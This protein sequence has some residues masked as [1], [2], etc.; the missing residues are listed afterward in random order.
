MIYR[1]AIFGSG[2][3]NV[4]DAGHVRGVGHFALCIHQPRQEGRRRAKPPSL[5]ELGGFQRLG[6]VHL[7]L[8]C[9]RFCTLWHLDGE[10]TMGV[11]GLNLVRIYACGK[12][13]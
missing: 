11:I 2:S 6:H 9:L 1:F 3:G 13:E 12:G 4:C 8:F 10:H 7:D 5:L